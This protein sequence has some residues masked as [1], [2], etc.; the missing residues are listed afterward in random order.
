M[1]DNKSNKTIYTLAAVCFLLL[2]GIGKVWTNANESELRLTN[3]I[4]LEQALHAELE[5]T[6]DSLGSETAKKLT[7]QTTVKDL[8]KREAKL[9]KDQKE[10]LAFVKV[11]D[12][13]K[14]L[15]AAVI[16]HDTVKVR[17]LASGPP[18]AFT[19]STVA[20]EVTT[21][22]IAY[23][24]TVENVSPVADSTKVPMLLLKNLYIPNQTRIS[25]EWGERKDGY[26]VS[27]SVTNTNPLFKIGNVESFAIPELQKS[28]VRPSFFQGLGTSLNTAKTPF[29]IGLGLGVIGVL[30]LTTR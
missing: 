9:T 29:L 15:I 22:S 10:L 6:R 16:I 24:A 20:F 17:E 7:L 3:Q 21:D 28:T 19:D 1:E 5:I 4:K 8:S 14:N 27:V 25:F 13:N 2:L 12:K 23:R 26:P 30:V 11:K 18:I